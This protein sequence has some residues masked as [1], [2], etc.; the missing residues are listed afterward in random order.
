MVLIFDVDTLMPMFSTLLPTKYNSL[1]QPEISHMSTDYI[2]NSLTPNS[3]SFTF[4]VS[5]TSNAD[6]QETPIYTI[7]IN[8][9]ESI[10]DGQI[11]WDYFGSGETYCNLSRVELVQAKDNFSQLYSK[12]MTASNRLGTQPEIIGLS[13]FNFASSVE[14]PSGNLAWSFPLD[15]FFIYNKKNTNNAVCIYLTQKNENI[16]LVSKHYAFANIPNNTCN[17]SNPSVPDTQTKN[18]PCHFYSQNSDCP[19]Y[20]YDSRIVYS[21]DVTTANSTEL[22]SFDLVYYL[23]AQ[24]SHTFKINNSSLNVI[25]NTLNYPSHI[26]YEDCLVESISIFTQ[27]MDTYSSS[28]FFLSEVTRDTPQDITKDTKKSS[29]ITSLISS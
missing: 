6:S 10:P 13:P 3:L 16:T 5:S 15:T 18:V 19:V 27:Y 8:H 24:G 28:D 29:Y 4:P 25:I 22:S 21:Q 23:S 2:I 20:E 9:M 14:A 26:S 1:S 17:C 12:Y 11:V 7:Y